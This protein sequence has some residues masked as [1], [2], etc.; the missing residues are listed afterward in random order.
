MFYTFSGNHALSTR[1]YAVQFS[2]VQCSAVQNSTEPWPR[3]ITRWVPGPVL[4]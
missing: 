1:E 4:V 3:R 2:T